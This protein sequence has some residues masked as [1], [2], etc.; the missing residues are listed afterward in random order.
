MLLEQSCNRV[1]LNSIRELVR[2]LTGT[3]R[4]CAQTAVGK[5]EATLDASAQ[6]AESLKGNKNTAQEGG[7]ILRFN[8]KQIKNLT[9]NDVGNLLDG[10]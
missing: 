6:Q 3:E 1:V 7:E 10:A 8:L 2:K 5:L 9:E 4:S